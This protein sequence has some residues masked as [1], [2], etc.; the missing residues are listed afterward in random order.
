METAESMH[1]VGDL[2][3]KE[4]GSAARFNAG[5]VPYQ[6]LD[7]RVL[8]KSVRLRSRAK[9]P[10][11]DVPH[12]ADILDKLA[13]WQ[14]GGAPVDLHAAVSL[15]ADD[16]KVATDDSSVDAWMG[17]PWDD[18]ARVF[19][20][21]SKKYNSWNWIKGQ[22]WSVPLASAVRHLLWLA[23]GIP[24]DEESGLSHF[25]HFLANIMMLDYFYGEYPDGDDR[26]PFLAGAKKG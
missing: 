20:Y 22:A 19:E 16:L 10:A 24:T 2:L 21:G 15:L 1:Q 8:A 14:H 3:S 7:I 12:L 26:P 4:P 6:F 9:G 13:D 11:A 17:I 18:C 5:K 25:G 23:S